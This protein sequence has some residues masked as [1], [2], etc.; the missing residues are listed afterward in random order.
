M[1]KVKSE[2]VSRKKPLLPPRGPR[3][4]LMSRPRTTAT[5]SMDNV[6]AWGGSAEAKAEEEEEDVGR[7]EVIEGD[8]DGQ[9]EHDA[10]ENWSGF[11]FSDWVILPPVVFV[12]TLVSS[13]VTRFAKC[14][15]KT[16][17]LA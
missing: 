14:P 8:A 2:P 10:G 11:W 17:A 6:K 1:S 16:L 9:A 3:S 12:L 7:V 5:V 15:H 4:T 13:P